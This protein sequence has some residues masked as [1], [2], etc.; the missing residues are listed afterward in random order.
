MMIYKEIKGLFF[1]ILFLITPVMYVMAQTNLPSQ[2]NIFQPNEI[3]KDLV[4]EKEINNLIKKGDWGQKGTSTNKYWIAYSDRGN[5]TTYKGPN[6]SSGKFDELKF[7]EKLRIA[8]INNGYA[9][10]Y[11]EPK[12]DTFYPMISEEAKSRGWV[13]MSNLLLWESCPVNEKDIYYKALLVANVDNAGQNNADLGYVYNN[14]ETKANPNGIETDMTF[15]YVMKTDPKSGL[16]LLSRQSTLKGASDQMLFGWVSNKSYT[17]WNQR[18]CL[19]PNWNPDAVAYFNSPQG[20]LYNFYSDPN[21]NSVVSSYMYGNK[22]DKDKNQYTYYR[23]DPY[24]TRFPVL[25]NDS[26]NNDIYKCTTFGN[27]G[28]AVNDPGKSDAESRRKIEE[29]TKQLQNINL[30]FV[31]DG[32]SSMK[33]YFAS[34]K[35]AIQQSI[36]YFDKNKYTVKA[37]VV[38]YRDYAD[39]DALVETLPLTDTKDGR[40][41]KFLDEVGNKNY[42]ANSSPNDRTHTEALYKGLETALDATKIGYNPDHANMMLVIGDCGNHLNDDK[43]MSEGQLLKKMVDNNIHLMS[44]QVRNNSA[45]PWQ[46]FNSQM[47]KFVKQNIEDQYKK[48]AITAKVKFKPNKLGYDIDNGSNK[49]LFVGATRFEDEGK[50][51]DA[52]NLT[53]L[54]TANIGNFSNAVQEQI[55][56][57]QIGASSGFTG[58]TGSALNEMDLQFLISKLGK[59]LAEDLIN[60]NVTIAT[61]S[62]VPIKDK[63]GRDYWKPIVFMS[64]AELD[65]LLK[66]L[67]KV[68]NDAT[69]VKE[70]NDRKPYIDA[71][72]ALLRAMVP[73]ITEAEMDQKGIA[74]VMNMISGLNV[75]TDALNYSLIDLADV[76]KV[77]NDKFQSLVNDF[78]DRYEKVRRIRKSNYTYAF[79]SN[80]VKYYWVPVEDLP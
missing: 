32:T 30:I 43:A 76:H 31:I 1:S 12:S 60:K 74:D 67:E 37:S 3:R 23:M 73:D 4:K 6:A 78:C 53:S 34:V 70:S 50:D 16:V 14:P 20:K 11:T 38:I 46:L 58:N 51:M 28:R 33:P 57:L 18:S 69:K 66:S 7:N 27:K 64:T 13:P 59:D 61:T 45:E 77:P 41:I 8:D 80:N 9:L 35:K 25:D 21:L 15:Y 71:V 72:K 19:E 52:N 10:V 68:Y 17:P 36:D 29:L 55:N 79:D 62:Y 75:K 65:E 56:V 26:K 5:N 54:I 47:S 44:Y 2:V 39:G 48:R 22:Y 24:M 42:G 49:Q 40:L 63:S